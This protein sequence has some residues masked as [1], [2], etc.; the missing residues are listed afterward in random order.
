MKREGCSSMSSSSHLFLSLSHEKVFFVKDL[1][2]FFR[3][4]LH[5]CHGFKGRFLRETRLVSFREKK[6]YIVVCDD[7]EVEN[8]F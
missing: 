1:K 6:K 3:T 4:F 5:G 2:N 8:V 7:R